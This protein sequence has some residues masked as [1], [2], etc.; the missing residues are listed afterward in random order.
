MNCI[1]ASRTLLATLLALAGLLPGAG[2]EAWLGAD[3]K[4]VPLK[5]AEQILD[6][7]RSAQV[8]SSI[9]L[10]D[11]INQPSKLL[12][13][14]DGIQMHA[15][16]RKVRKVK[17]RELKYSGRRL[18]LRDDFIFERAAYETAL[19]LGLDNVP[20]V[21]ERSI[22]GHPGTLQLWIERARTVRQD[23]SPRQSP[24]LKQ[25]L[26]KQ[27]ET[28]WVFDNLIYNDDRNKGNV[29]ISQDGKLWMIDH[30]QAFR[31]FEE[32]PY[33]SL[34]TRCSRS[35]FQRLKQLDAAQISQALMPYLEPKELQAL[36]VRRELL[37]EHIESLI[38]EN[39]ESSV[40]Y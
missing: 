11:G 8:A 5:S 38:A 12:L 26:L 4:P 22:D 14:K 20:P 6:F 7:L 36:I 40:L 33:P 29:L 19:L 3:G 10:T 30:T 17:V 23:P 18:E 35:L 9:E 16:F 39:G 13:E 27:H 37:V 24:S 28:M 15:V 1:M 2:H 34:V 32:L 31:T 25:R 21:V